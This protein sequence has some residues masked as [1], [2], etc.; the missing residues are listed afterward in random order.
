[1]GSKG[2]SKRPRFGRKITPFCTL[3]HF[4][5]IFYG[6]GFVFGAGFSQK[7]RTITRYVLKVL[8]FMALGSFSAPDDA[9]LLRFN[10]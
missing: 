1:M 4:A 9:F 7:N 10:C 2:R 3:S 5:C 6:F 8:S